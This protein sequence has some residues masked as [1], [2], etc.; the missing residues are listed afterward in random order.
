MES[1]ELFEMIYEFTR[2]HEEWELDEIILCI[3]AVLIALTWYAI[4]TA[5][6]LGRAL[7]QKQSYYNE[8]TDTQAQ[9]DEISKSREKFVTIAHSELQSSVSQVTVAL[10]QIEQSETK[11]D[12]K[13]NILQVRVLSEGM[14]QYS[15]DIL[16]VAKHIIGSEHGKMVDF[17][18][19]SCISAAVA[20]ARFKARKKGLEFITSYHTTIQSSHYGNPSAIRH[21]VQNLTEHS[22]MLTNEG[23]VKVQCQF[24]KKNSELFITV[25]DTAQSASYEAHQKIF[26]NAGNDSETEASGGL[27]I[28]KQLVEELG[29]SIM[30]RPNKPHGSIVSVMLQYRDTRHLCE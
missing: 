23:S 28:V 14:R 3:P 25:S 5:R 9:M 2:N 17:D 22:V 27:L 12:L 26:E 21:I 15:A 1:V 6:K 24:N 30:I 8:L 16:S 13:Q 18:F 20:T 29:G 19:R 7:K 4:F 10:N 11:Q